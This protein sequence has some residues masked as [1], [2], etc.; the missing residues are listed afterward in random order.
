MPTYPLYPDRNIVA[1]DGL[2][3]FAWLGE[4]V[5]YDDARPSGITYTHTVSVPGVFDT[6]PD[7]VG[8]RG[9]GIYRTT[10]HV[11]DE[12]QPL[13]LKLGGL[14]LRG[15][16]YCDGREIAATEL[17]YSPLTVGLP[18]QQAG[19]HELAIV[20]DNR[21]VT[22]PPA[23]FF[24]NFDFY[25]YGGIYR[26]VQLH[27]VPDCYLDR[28]K[29]ALTDL[30]R[31][32]VSLTVLLGGS[33]PAQL[34]VRVAFDGGTETT[35]RV[36]VTNGQATI[37]TDVPDGKLWSPQTP[38]LHTVT[39]SLGGENG[40]ARDTVVESFGLREIKAEAGKILL[41]GEPVKLLGFNRHEAHPEFGPALPEAEMV[42]DLQYMKDMGCNFVRGAHYPQNQAFLDLC[43]RMGFL[44]WEESLGWGDAVER[45]TDKHFGDLQ[46]EQTRLMVR[47]SFNHPSV[48]VW[49]FLNEGA[50]N[51][52]D[53]RGLYTRLIR[54]IREEDP[55]RLVS[56]ASNR[57]TE[58][59]SYRDA[60]LVSMNIYPAW[61]DSPDWVQ[62]QPFERIRNM[63]DKLAAFCS[64]P[65]LREKP[66]ILSEIGTC[67]LYGWHDPHRA[68]W[69]EEYQADYL[70]ETIRAVF[71]NPRL[72]G[73]AIWQL[74][75]TRSYSCGE[76]RGKSRGFNNAG[77]IDEYRRPKLA[78]GVVKELYHR[79]GN[80]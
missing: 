47:T 52:P 48:I 39:V 15:R 26:S 40:A 64:S 9:T 62:V 25:G 75:D 53:S 35:H 67:A 20:V 12:K 22:T 46:E 44:V 54:A 66:F 65:E 56:Y 3:D 1:L 5:A 57:A 29:V 49:A 23:L 33:V 74:Y 61:I 50:S 70:R 10:V 37:E 78:Y 51:H 77:V 73:I 34:D 32:R 7:F 72:S 36:S 69:S 24:P 21:F 18:P 17:S 31:R 71:D 27:P 30:S 19:G 79:Y 41:N 60:D 68:G 16:I 42:R 14:G 6:L 45:L 11:R 80:A 63:V 4:T 28:V 76:M 58:D 55:S 2:W 8:Q 59:L 13:L 38:H 43:D